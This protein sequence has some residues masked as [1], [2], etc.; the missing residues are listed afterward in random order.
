MFPLSR[1]LFQ[2][3][4]QLSNVD[5]KHKMCYK[6]KGWIKGGMK[7]IQEIFILYSKTNFS[8]TFL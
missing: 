8:Q 7:K 1:D 6:L 2:E 3:I 5:W 4:I